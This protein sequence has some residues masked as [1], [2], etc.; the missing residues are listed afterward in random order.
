MEDLENS[1]DSYC[2][3]DYIPSP[4]KDENHNNVTP[5]SPVVPRSQRSEARQKQKDGK[6]KAISDAT[7]SLKQEP[8][9]KIIYAGPPKGCK[10]LV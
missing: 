8:K 6:H 5:D 10:S 1:D 9:R 7:K 2:D 4:E 3:P